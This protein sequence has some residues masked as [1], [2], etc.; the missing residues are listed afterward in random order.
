MLFVRGEL[1]FTDLKGIWRI[2]SR[3]I[4][5]E[6]LLLKHSQKGKFTYCSVGENV[7]SAKPIAVHVDQSNF[8]ASCLY[9]A[10][11]ADEVLVENLDEAFYRCIF[12]W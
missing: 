10:N 11:N 7:R 4:S 1:V 8:L 9:L 5:Q 12:I 6:G 2:C 3:N